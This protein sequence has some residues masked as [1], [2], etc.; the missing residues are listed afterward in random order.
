MN[1]AT[2]KRKRQKPEKP[3]PDFPLTAHRNGQWCKKVRGEIYFF[4]VWEK[5]DEALNCWL[6]DKDAI[7]AGR[8]RPSRVQK[9]I[10]VEDVCTAYLAQQEDRYE[11]GDLQRVSLY[12][13][14]ASLKRVCEILGKKTPVESLTPDDFARLRRKLSERFNANSLKIEIGRAK[15]AFKFAYDN[16]LIEKPVRYGTKF[17]PPSRKQIQRIKN[18]SGDRSFQQEEL[19]KLLSSAG[20]PLK[21]FILLGLNCGFGNRDCATLP[22]SAVDLESDWIEFPRAKNARPRRCPLWPETL[23]AL[24]EAF[25]VRPEPRSNQETNLFFLKNSGRCWV[26]SSGVKKNGWIDD[27]GPAFRKLMKETGTFQPRRNFYGLRKTFRTIADET[28][29]FPAIDLIMGHSPSNGDMSDHYRQRI[30]DERLLKVSNR[31]RSWVFP[32]K[33]ASRKK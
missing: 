20:A 17:N 1:N 4:G 28:L 3:H 16:L 26:R 29:D 10:T 25:E 15:A 18:E 33:S 32:Q 9:G 12:N 6:E 23:R 30:E 7:L 19:E 13:S 2:K 11:A 27:L 5:P 22:L 14:N 8:E 31:V 24:R 21:A